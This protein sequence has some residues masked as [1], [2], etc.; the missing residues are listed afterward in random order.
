MK[1]CRQ[2]VKIVWA[3]PLKTLIIYKILHSHFTYLLIQSHSSSLRWVVVQFSFRLLLLRVYSVYTAKCFCCCKWF[4]KQW[5][6][7]AWN[8]I[9]LVG[10]YIMYVQWKTNRVSLVDLCASHLL[11]ILHIP[12]T[13]SHGHD[14]CLLRSLRRLKTFVM[15]ILITLIQPNIAVVYRRFSFTSGLTSGTSR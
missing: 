5:S 2:R 6:I 8:G 14:Y 12:Q 15:S 13:T 7:I 9:Q 1:N 4:A 11:H 10:Y 3:F